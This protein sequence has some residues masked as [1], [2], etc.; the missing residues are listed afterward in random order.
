MEE[1][2]IYQEIAEA[3]KELDELKNNITVVKAEL[4]DL[5]LETTGVET[6]K[7]EFAAKISEL[8][9]L[10]KNLKYRISEY[11]KKLANS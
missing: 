1:Q 3:Q 4:R 11:E 8:I 2:R 10:E 7:E 5:K 9:A 6:Q